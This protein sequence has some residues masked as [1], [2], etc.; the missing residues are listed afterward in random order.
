[1]AK[2]FFVKEG[3]EEDRLVQQKDVNIDRILDV[4]TKVGLHYVGDNLPILKDNTNKAASSKDKKFLCRDPIRVFIKISSTEA[5][6]TKLKKGCYFVK[7]VRPSDW[8]RQFK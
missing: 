4:F 5:R 6:Q 2:V 8:N 3:K 7:D 1:M